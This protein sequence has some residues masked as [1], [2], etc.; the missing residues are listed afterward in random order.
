MLQVISSSPGELEPVFQAMLANATQLCEAKFGT[1]WLCE[2]DGFAHAALAQRAARIAEEQRRELCI[3]AA[4]G[5]PRPR[6]EDPAGGPGCRHECDPGLSRPRPVVAAVEIAGIRT[7]VSVPML[8]ESEVVGAI[9]SIA[10][11]YGRS[12][13]GRS[14][15]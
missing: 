6:Y 9:A 4:G 11:R 10:R 8:K 7:L 12:P 2:G 15:W 13:K 14:S 5:Q 1:L 3:S